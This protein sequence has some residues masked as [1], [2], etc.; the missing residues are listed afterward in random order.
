MERFGAI[1]ASVL[2]GVGGAMDTVIV[3]TEVM[4]EIAVS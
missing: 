1:V 2:H 4:S 3:A